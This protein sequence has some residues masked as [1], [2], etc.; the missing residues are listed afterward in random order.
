MNKKHRLPFPIL[1]E[2]DDV[3]VIEKPAGLLATHTKLVGRLARESQLTAEN[4]LNDYV[5]KGQAKSKKRVWLVH[6]LDRETS[7]VM[8]FAKSE[9]VAEKFRADWA[10]LTEK[11]YRARVEGLLEE[12]SGTF[13]SYLL[14]DADGYRVRS[15][16]AP[17][18]R[19]ASRNARTPKLA[20]T[21]WRRLSTTDGT[22]LVEV[23][24]KTGRK[25]QIRVHFSEAG[26][27]VIGDEKYGGERASRLYLHA[28]S[29][30]FRHPRTGGW[31]EFTAPPPKGLTDP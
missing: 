11:T 14:E 28:L 21:E 13:E 2:D 22:T 10:S 23:K 29:L 8:M 27:P 4:L 24:L 25:N 31:L 15:V 1:F 17:D 18:A 16:A 6:R 20:R 9:E 12:E 3:I 26:H 7:G 5:R 19:R 30:R